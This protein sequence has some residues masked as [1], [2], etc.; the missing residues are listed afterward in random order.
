VFHYPTI[1]A[2]SRHVAA[3]SRAAVPVTE[4]LGNDSMQ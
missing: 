3:R 4:P 1:S 2:R